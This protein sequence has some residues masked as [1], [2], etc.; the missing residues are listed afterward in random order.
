VNIRK[1]LEQ[2]QA[3]QDADHAEQELLKAGNL[4]GGS[5]GVVGTD[6]K[7]YG[8]CHRLAL[9]RLLGADKDHDSNR[10][11]MFDA[12]RQ[13]EE[14]WAAKLIAAGATILREDEI[15]IKWQVPGT[16]RFV[17][18]RPDIVIGTSE[19]REIGALAET[20]PGEWTADTVEEFTPNFGLELKGIYSAS[21]AVRVEL[22]GIPDPKH[23]AQAG[24][25]SMALDVPYA[26]CYTN[27]SVVEI[28]YW[29]QKR[30]PGRGKKLQPFYRIFYLRWNESDQLEYRDEQNDEWVQ[31]VYTKQGIADYYS[32]IVEME[33][34]QELGPRPEGG[35]A[36]G[37]PM[38]FEKCNYCP[39]KAAC[40]KH[41]D[42]YADWLAAI[43]T[44]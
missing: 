44:E 29:A 26:I 17:T 25:Y 21:S 2:G 27:P 13:A 16:D 19:I 15:P 36:D 32:L 8:E 6:G 28:P 10:A 14:S 24:F 35:Y 22:E 42:S 9:A 41:E 39:L 20:G 33:A 11:I 3:K 40:D 30:F 43:R 5:A 7:I 37:R 34:K 12:G 31:T 18:G 4:R 23:L 38:P 1:L